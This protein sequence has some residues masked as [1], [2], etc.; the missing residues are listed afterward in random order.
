LYLDSERPVAIL[1][2]L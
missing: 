2:T 1:N